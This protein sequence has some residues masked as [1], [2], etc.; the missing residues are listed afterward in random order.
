LPPASDIFTTHCSAG[1]QITYFS[2]II[3]GRYPWIWD[4]EGKVHQVLHHDPNHVRVVIVPV[5]SKAP[6]NMQVYLNE[7]WW[8][9]PHSTVSGL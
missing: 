7:T 3:A 9:G 2:P 6:S 8:I 5:P 1:Q 4:R